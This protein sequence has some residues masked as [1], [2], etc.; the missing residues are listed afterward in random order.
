MTA[1][2]II[3]LVLVLISLVKIGVFFVN[4]QAWYTEKT[5]PLLKL[6]GSK[7]STMVSGLVL[8]I[9]VL[10]YL[11]GEMTITQ[12]FASFVFAFLFVLFVMAPYVSKLFDWVKK[13]SQKPSFVMDNMVGIVA[14]VVLMV[15]VLIDIF[16]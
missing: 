4:P 1:V 6:F 10:S 13:E 16:G 11:L 9:I 8:S 5:N 14:W 3:A 2:Q 12:V 15:W 7:M